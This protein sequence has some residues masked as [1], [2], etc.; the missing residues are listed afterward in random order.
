M[1]LGPITHI[2]TTRA[3]MEQ[4]LTWLAE[5]WPA[6]SAQVCGACVAVYAEI[7]GTMPHHMAGQGCSADEQG[8]PY[9]VHDIHE[10][11]ESWLRNSY[12]PREVTS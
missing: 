11:I 6:F 4:A 8:L 9:S 1:S 2:H 5:E 3:G 10:T 7:D 12:H